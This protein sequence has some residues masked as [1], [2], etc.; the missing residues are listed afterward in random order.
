MRKVEKTKLRARTNAG[1]Q[2]RHLAALFA[3]VLIGSSIVA[4]VFAMI[5]SDTDGL[6]VLLLLSSPALFLAGVIVQ[7]GALGARGPRT[8][9]RF[10]SRN[11]F[12]SLLAS[13]S[14]GRLPEGSP[15]REATEGKQEHDLSLRPCAVTPSSCLRGSRRDLGGNP[16]P[17]A[18]LREGDRRTEDCGGRR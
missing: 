17:W 15:T 10:W 12:R 11:R 4:F 7:T 3:G 18:L 5:E 13:S 14:T 8:G 16:K 6:Q 2:Y 1:R 9:N